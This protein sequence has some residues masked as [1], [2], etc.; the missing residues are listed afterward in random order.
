MPSPLRAET[1]SFVLTSVPPETLLNSGEYIAASLQRNRRLLVCQTYVTYY[2]RHTILC[3]KPPSRRQ[4]SKFRAL[5][6][7]RLV[8]APLKIFFRRFGRPGCRS[9]GFSGGLPT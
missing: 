1:F 8:G 5:A 4:S 9:N 7:P 6:L 2:V 3:L